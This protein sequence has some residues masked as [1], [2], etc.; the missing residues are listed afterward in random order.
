MRRLGW[1][2]VAS[3][4]RGWP[5]SAAPIRVTILH[6]MSNDDGSPRGG[7]LLP[8]AAK[9]TTRRPL[10]LVFGSVAAAVAAKREMEGRPHG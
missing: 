5:V 4:G 10:L 3:A 6:E 9:S 1:V 8:A 7:L 2:T